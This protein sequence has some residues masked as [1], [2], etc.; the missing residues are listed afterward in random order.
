MEERCPFQDTLE[1][2]G[3][4]HTLGVLRLLVVKNPRRFTELQRGMAV[5]PK[6]LTARLREL[7]KAGILARSAF[8]EIP[9]RVEYSLTPKGQELVKLF[10]HIEAWHR[11]YV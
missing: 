6:V 9:P 7:V 5:N 4:K 8:G 1:L 10:G 11:V 2:L 3:R